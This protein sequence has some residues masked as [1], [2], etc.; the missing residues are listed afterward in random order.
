MRIEQSP[1]D[2]DG[3]TASIEQFADAPSESARIRRD[4]FS[5]PLAVGRPAIRVVAR[6]RNLAGVLRAEAT[7]QAGVAQRTRCLAHAGLSAR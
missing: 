4:T 5:V 6:R 7:K 2:D 3:E 1:P